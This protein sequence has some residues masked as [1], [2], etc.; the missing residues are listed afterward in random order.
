[1][2]NRTYFKF[3]MNPVYLR[4]R[5]DTWVQFFTQDDEVIE[6][7][8]AGANTFNLD[9]AYLNTTI[10]AQVLANYFVFDP[11]AEPEEPLADLYEILEK[12]NFNLESAEEEEGLGL[13][14][15]DR[16]K[17]SYIVVKE[18]AQKFK[19]GYAIPVYA[20]NIHCLQRVTL[21]DIINKNNAIYPT[22]SDGYYSF[23][24]MKGRYVL[25]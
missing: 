19:Q 24:N 18:S 4:V 6:H 15:S 16:V 22:Y 5:H 25:Y 8:I 23:L 10:Y 9:E 1:M 17:P 2:E 21:Y 12:D 20:N 13:F 7:A 14:I 11:L 3:T